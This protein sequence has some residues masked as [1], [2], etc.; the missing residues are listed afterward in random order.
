LLIKLL[1]PSLAQNISVA[2]IDEQSAGGAGL[3]QVLLSSKGL[4]VGVEHCVL[5]GFSINPAPPLLQ[6]VK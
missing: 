3:Q 2:L 6:K 1:F 4:H 5:T